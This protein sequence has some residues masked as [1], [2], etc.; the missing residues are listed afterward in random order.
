MI[1]FSTKPWRT[2][3]NQPVTYDGSSVEWR[4]S[5]YGVIIHDDQVLLMQDKNNY[6]Y[7][8]P[9]GGVE[10]GET[11]EEGIAREMQEE[12]GAH[13]QV[14]KL[15]HSTEDWFYHAQEERFYHAVLLFYQADLVSQLGQPSDEKVTFAGFVPLIQL[16]AQ[17]T[18]PLVW[19]VLQPFLG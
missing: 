5:G 15:L 17:N 6:L 10:L 9:G 12:L 13:I 1:D 18:N 4:I 14:G 8:V 2:A 16:T 3:N 7:T 11:I 19:D